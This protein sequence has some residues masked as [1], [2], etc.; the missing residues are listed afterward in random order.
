MTTKI[1]GSWS[2]IYQSRLFRLQM[3]NN[4]NRFKQNRNVLAQMNVKSRASSICS[5]GR[6]EREEYGQTMPP[7][8]DISE[9]SSWCWTHFGMA[10]LL[11]WPDG[12]VDT[13]ITFSSFRPSSIIEKKTCLLSNSPG[14]CFYCYVGSFWI[15]WPLLT[16][17]SQR[18]M[19]FGLTGT[20]PC[21][22]SLSWKWN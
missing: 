2:F 21:V 11:G 4:K 3:N 6:N 10:F 16:S 7:D 9:L 15:M 22:C 14:T 20:K 1:W 17:T 12:Y 8:P 13:I 5:M 19:A 18:Y